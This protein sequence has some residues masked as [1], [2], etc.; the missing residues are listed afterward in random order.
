MYAGVPRAF[1]LQSTPA[2]VG[3]ACVRGEIEDHDALICDEDVARLE[4][5]VQHASAVQRVDTKAN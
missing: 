5:A 1:R 4:V 2:R 3:R